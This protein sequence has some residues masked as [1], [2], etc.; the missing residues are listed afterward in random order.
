MSQIIARIQTPSP[1]IRSLINSLLLGVGQAHPQALIYPLSVASRSTSVARKQAASIILDRMRAQNNVLV[2][3]ALSIS[4]ELI[5]VAIL[6]PEMWHE[7]LE[8]A[9]RL[10]FTERDPEGMIAV[11]EPLHTQL[12]QV[13]TIPLC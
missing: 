5:R 13:G 11:L 3:E 8:E 9:S 12:E 1:L 4:Q 10:Y 6:W 7:G 2:E